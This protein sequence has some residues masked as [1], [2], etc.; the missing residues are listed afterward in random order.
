M[1]YDKKFAREYSLNV[2]LLRIG[3]QVE[4]FTVSAPFFENFEH[5]LIHQG[6]INVSIRIQ[7]TKGH[8]DTDWHITGWAEVNCD[9][10]G[11]PYPHALDV[12][13][14]LIYSF[15]ENVKYDTEE[16]INIDPDD[17]QLSLVQEIYD[18]IHLSLPMRFVPEPEVHTCDEAV[19]KALGLIED[20]GEDTEDEEE[21]I[22]P[23][24]AALKK[25]KD[26]LD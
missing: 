24:W 6:E 1:A 20:E 4:T 9:R 16:V 18:F 11:E 19:L 8:M 10:C 23:R 14:K 13:H 22:D 12:S 2:P 7:K 26:K 25:L 3:E 21:E 5:S 15:R 17:T